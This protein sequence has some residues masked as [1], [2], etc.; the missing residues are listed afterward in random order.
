MKCDK[1]ETVM[2]QVSRVRK[3]LEREELG[4]MTEGQEADYMAAE[5]NDEFAESSDFSVTEAKFRCPKCGREI[6]VR[7]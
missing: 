6:I 2:V 3:L 4:D 1:D 5:L 7:E